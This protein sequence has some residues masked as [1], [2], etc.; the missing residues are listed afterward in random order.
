MQKLE[1][2][3]PDVAKSDGPSVCMLELVQVGDEHLYV[4]NWKNIP[5]GSLC[6]FK[7]GLILDNN[8]IECPRVRYHKLD[9]LFRVI[10]LSMGLRR[11]QTRSPVGRTPKKP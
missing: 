1:N 4:I 10:K 9:V 11:C 5:E 6:W 8:A 3:L 2:P 7:N